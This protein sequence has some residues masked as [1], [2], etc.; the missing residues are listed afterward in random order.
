MPEPEKIPASLQNKIEIVPEAGTITLKGAF[1]ATQVRTIE[2]AFQTS[3]GKET[4]RQALT[5]LHGPGVIR[6]KTA[7]ELGE[8]FHV[9]LLALKQGDLWEHFEE[10][11]LLQ[12]DWRLI[13][14]SCELNETELK[15]PTTTAQGGRFVVQ[16]ERVRFEYFDNIEAQLAF[17]DFHIEWDRVQLISWFERNIPDDSILPDEK[18]AFLDNDF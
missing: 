17:F 14:Y 1:T 4:I 7:S 12:G 2:N 15:K 8:L 11:H 16:E 6:P 13:E 10:T 3:A 18:A 5:R 9:P